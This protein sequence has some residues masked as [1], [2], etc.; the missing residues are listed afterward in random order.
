MIHV[1]SETVGP[2]PALPPA[3]PEGWALWALC[4]ATDCGAAGT[5][6]PTPWLIQRLAGAP[7]HRFEPR[8]RCRCGARRA[9]LAIAP[10]RQAPADRPIFVFR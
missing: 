9:R 8:L 4:E 3:L 7:L 6:D 1:S 5:V 10:D 2:A